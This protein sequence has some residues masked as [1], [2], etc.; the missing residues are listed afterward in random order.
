MEREVYAVLSQETCEAFEISFLQH[1]EICVV[2]NA[3]KLCGNALSRRSLSDE[4]GVSFGFDVCLFDGAK[5]VNDDSH[6]RK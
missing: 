5:V 3:D 2:G 6:L 4:H 1:E